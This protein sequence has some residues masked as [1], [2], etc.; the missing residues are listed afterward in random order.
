MALPMTAGLASRLILR[1]VAGYLVFKA[2]LPQEIADMIAAD[3]EIAGL[4]GLAI[5]A[6]VEGAYTLAKRWGWAT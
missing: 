3:P 2:V 6:G 4:V 5:T 1:Y